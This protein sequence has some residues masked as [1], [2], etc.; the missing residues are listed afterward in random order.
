MRCQI[1]NA[2]HPGAADCHTQP[3]QDRS[4][5]HLQCPMRLPSQVRTCPLQHPCCSPARSRPGGCLGE[6]RASALRVTVAL[7]KGMFREFKRDWG[8]FKLGDCQ[9]SKGSTRMEILGSGSVIIYSRAEASLIG[10]RQW[11]AGRKTH[12]TVQQYYRLPR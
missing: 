6:E 5:I 10:P 4:R 12:N 11:K 3:P 1:V 2:E 8:S 7:S 9:D